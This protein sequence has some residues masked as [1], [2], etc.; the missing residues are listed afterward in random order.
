MARDD[1]LLN[2][3]IAASFISPTVQANGIRLD[4]GY[5]TEF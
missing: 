1:F 4:P 3:G 5:L 2:L